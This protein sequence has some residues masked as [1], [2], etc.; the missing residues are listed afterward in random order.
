[1][2]KKPKFCTYMIRCDSDGNILD[3]LVEKIANYHRKYNENYY[4]QETCEI[5]MYSS[6]L[7]KNLKKVK[8]QNNEK[9]NLREL[10]DKE[11]IRI[12]VT[13][14]GNIVLI[15]NLHEP[16]GTKIDLWGT[17]YPNGF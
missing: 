1:M 12:T 8:A 10:I 17:I 11:N 15:S 9:F 5:D 3:H 13:N 7:I 2:S 6:K 16:E 4:F 14:E